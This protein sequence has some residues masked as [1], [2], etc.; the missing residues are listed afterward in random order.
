VYVRVDSIEQAIRAS[1]IASPSLD[2][3]G[4]VAYGVAERNLRIDR[5]VSADPVNPL[6][7]TRDVW[8]NVAKRVEGETM[9]IELTC[10]DLKQH[11]RRVK[12]RVIHI[13]GL[14]VPAWADVIA[15]EYHP[16]HRERLVVDSLVRTTQQNVGL[17]RE[18]LWR[19]LADRTLSS[20]DISM[21]RAWPG[22][23]VVPK[24]ASLPIAEDQNWC[25]SAASGRYRY[26]STPLFAGSWMGEA[27]SANRAQASCKEQK[28]QWRQ[29]CGSMPDPRFE[30][31]IAQ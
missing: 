7:S 18:A 22:N 10:S 19:V 2:E 9:E 13:P 27:L 24:C 21:N 5:V 4:Y 20:H 15:R 12:T 6:Q 17:I 16:G 1:A 29:Y 26:V 3:V 30:A 31:A 11:R 14:I 25:A 28:H 23:T 8:L